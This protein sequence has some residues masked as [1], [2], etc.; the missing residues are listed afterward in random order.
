VKARIEQHGS[1][2]DMDSNDYRFQLLDAR[3]LIG[4]HL[5]SVGRSAT[6]IDC[7]GDVAPDGGSLDCVVTDASGSTSTVRLMRRG[8]DHRLVNAD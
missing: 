6:S 2:W 4:L 1:T 7:P 5:A 3:T 8:G